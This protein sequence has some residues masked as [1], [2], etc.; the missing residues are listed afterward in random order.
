M[1]SLSPAADGQQL[2]IGI[3]ADGFYKLT[4]EELSTAGFDLSGVDAHT[5]KIYNRVNEIP[6][7]V[8]GEQDG[9]FDPGD[10]ILFY[11]QANADIYTIVNIYWLSTGG[12][13]GLRMASRSGA[14]GGAQLATQFP[15][16]LH[17]E[18]DTITGRPCRMGGVRTTGFGTIVSVP[19]AAPPCPLTVNIR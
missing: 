18:Q 14:P 13:P 11:G 1:E 2:K 9:Q 3:T 4:Y 5:I 12:D 10:W 8:E 15:V 6:I 16:R 7:L 19:T 17:A